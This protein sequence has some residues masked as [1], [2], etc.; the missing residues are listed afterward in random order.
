MEER[1]KFRRVNEITGTFVLVLVAVLVAA[2][3]WTGRSQ[4]WFKGNVTLRIV[5]PFAVMVTPQTKVLRK[6]SM[7]ASART[8]FSLRPSL[9]SAGSAAGL[10][11]ARSANSSMISPRCG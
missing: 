2:V 4:R 5:L 9:Y 6:R 3:M 7:F 8:T 11:L 1:F 10:L